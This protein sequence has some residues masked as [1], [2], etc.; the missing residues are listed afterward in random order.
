MIT[1]DEKKELMSLNLVPPTIK[2]ELDECIK[3]AIILKQNGIDLK[4]LVLSKK[5]LDGSR[6]YKL[7]CELEQDGVDI[8]KI[9]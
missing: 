8:Q 7:L 1:E 6:E 3:I 5:S 9:I 2:D 4:N